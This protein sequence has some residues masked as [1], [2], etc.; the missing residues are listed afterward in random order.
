MSSATSL[1]GF[2]DDATHLG[3][4][5]TYH[6]IDDR[7]VFQIDLNI[8]PGELLFQL[9]DNVDHF[10]PTAGGPTTEETIELVFDDLIFVD[11]Q[12]GET[13]TLDAVFRVIDDTP[14]VDVIAFNQN[15]SA[16][17]WNLDETTDP[18]FD[19]VA[20]EGLDTYGAGDSLPHDDDG[21][22]D[23]TLSQSADPTGTFPFGS[24]S[25]GNLGGLF[26]VN[27]L[28]G[29]DGEKSDDRTLTLKLIEFGVGELAV[30]TGL[31]TTLEATQPASGGNPDSNGADAIPFTPYADPGIYLFLEPGGTA[32]TGRVGNS[33]SGPIAFRITLTT[34]DPATAQLKVDQ[35]LAIDHPTTPDTFDEQLNLG[36][37]GDTS[38]GTIEGIALNLSVTLTDGD[39]DTDTDDHSAFITN[40]FRFDDDGP[41]I[42]QAN[43]VISA[44]LEL[45]ELIVLPNST[46]DE[47]G[48]VAAGPDDQAGVTAVNG[49]NAIGLDTFAVGD[50]ISGIDFGQDGGTA[51]YSLIMKTER[52]NEPIVTQILSTDFFATHPAP[53]GNPDFDGGGQFEPYPASHDLGQIFLFQINP[54]TIEGYVGEDLGAPVGPL[55]L[56]IT[57]DPNTGVLTMQQYLAL[58]H[59]DTTDHDDALVGDSNLL[60]GV[61]AKLTATDGDGDQASLEIPVDVRIE[62]DGPVAVLTFSS[63]TIVYDETAGLDL[64]SNDVGGT[65]P[66]TV[67]PAGLGT[68]IGRAAITGWFQ[69]TGSNF[70]TDGAAAVN[71]TPPPVTPIGFSLAIFAPGVDSGLDTV[72]GRSIFL[73]VENGLVVG[74]PETTIGSGAPGSGVGPVA[75]VLAVNGTNGNFSVNQYM[76]IEHGNPLDP[77]ESATP[78]TFDANTVFGR[79]RVVDGDGDA[80]VHSIDISLLIKIEDDGSIAV[81]DTDD[82]GIGNS[83]TGNVITD[84]AAGDAGDTDAGADT[85]GTDGGAISGVAAGD[86]NT[87]ITDGTGVGGLGVDGTFGTLILNADGSYTYNRTS[88]SGG[89]DVFTYTLKDGDG[90]ADTATLT[91]DLDPQTPPP[92]QGEGFSAAI[93]EDQLNPASIGG[94]RFP[95]LATGNEDED[96]VAGLDTDEDATPGPQEFNNITHWIINDDNSLGV[97]GG[98]APLDFHFVV[99]NGTQ[100]LING[101]VPLTSEG[102]AVL[103]HTLPDGNTLIGY[104]ETFGGSGYQTGDR[105]VFDMLITSETG[106]GQ[107]NFILYDNID[108]HPY[109]GTVLNPAGLPIDNVEN[110]VALNLNGVI[111]VT[112]AN[113]DDLLLN[114]EIQIIDDIPIA[115]ADSAEV[116]FGETTKS[117]VVLIIDRSGSMAG[118]FNTV[119]QAIEDL[120]DSGLV[121]SVR[122]LSFSDGASNQFGPVGGWFTDLDAAFFAVNAL[123][124]DG[125]TDYDA[126]LSLL[127]STYSAPPAGGDRLI[128]LFLSDGE[129]NEDNGTGSDGIDEDDTDGNPAPG[130]EETDWINFLTTNGFDASYAIGFGGLTDADRAHLEPI[131]WQS[132]ETADNPYDA[133]DNGVGGSALDDPN[134]IITNVNDLAQVLQEATGASIAGNVITN[135]TVTTADDD[136]FG[137]DGPGYVTTL[138]WDTDGDGDVDGVDDAGYQFN[139]TALSLN[140]GAFVAGGEAT[141]DTFFD[142]SFTF[143][144]LTGDWEYTT[145]DTVNVQFIEHFT[146][147]LSDGDGDQTAATALNITVL[148]PPP[149]FTVSDATVVD[150]GDKTVFEINLSHAA[151]GP[152]V[153]SLAFTNGS[154]EGSDYNS[155]TY[156]FSTDG[157]SYSNVVGNQITIPTS[158]TQVFVRVQTNEDADFDDETFT[159]T[160]TKVSGPT[161]TTSDAGSA[162]I[163]DD[164]NAAPVLALNSLLAVRD[165]FQTVAYTNQNGTAN[166]S[167]NWSE[168]GDDGNAAIDG[169][170]ADDIGIVADANGGAPAGNSALRVSDFIAGSGTDGDDADASIQRQV[171]LIGATTATLTFDHRSILSN[172][173]DDVMIQVA[174]AAGG[175]FTTLLT[176]DGSNNDTNYDDASFNISAF[177]SATTT[178]RIVSTGAL[179]EDD[180]VFFDNITITYNAASE[181]FE[182]TYT[183][184]GAPASIAAAGPTIS[185]A[186]DTQMEFANIVLA[187]AQAGDVLS[188]GALP[189][190]ILSTIVLGVGTITVQLS[191]TASLAAYQAAIQ[192]VAFSTTSDTPSPVDRI[193]NVTVNDGE[194]DSNIAT[195]TMN[196]VPVS[197][198]PTD[199]LVTGNSGIAV[200]GGGAGDTTIASGTV[201]FTLS[202]VDPDDISG[203]TYTFNG[204]GTAA[205]T[206]DGD[207]ETFTMN[208]TTGAVT[209]TALAYGNPATVVMSVRSTD[210]D[211][212]ARNETVTLRLGENGVNDTLDQS[213]TT[214]DQVIYGL[215]GND[216]LLGGSARDWLNGGAG[217]DT[218]TGGG[219]AD[220]IDTGAANDDVQDII[221]FNNVTEY[222]DLVS[223]FDANG[224]DVTDDRILFGGALN[225]L[226]DDGNDDENFLSATG[227]GIAG[228]VS[229]NVGDGNS[230][231]ELLLLTGAGGEGVTNA[232]LTNAALV[233]AAFNAEFNI[234]AANGNDAVLVINDTDANSFAVWQYIESTGGA[235]IAA[236]EIT[237]IGRFDANGAISTGNL[238]LV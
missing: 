10:E 100:A 152:I 213:I 53:G 49:V 27:K 187:N 112:D 75:I 108:H 219:G 98:V 128:S 97:A 116:A 131:A 195:T 30:G 60:E 51:N 161:A 57:I 218:M 173:N 71:P 154:A 109:G 47:S 29:A 146:Y 40:R 170:G 105:V 175:P 1:F 182:T 144:F 194:V 164:D 184:N 76:A 153:L 141:F 135:L 43:R 178:I 139:G 156:E 64:D 125:S 83:E 16:Q 209:T 3:A 157:I 188:V 214:N 90:D 227:N 140:G 199:I 191:G 151:S 120:F 92:G 223:N 159:L 145:P 230:D 212:A 77:D 165:T 19:D 115:L 200:G 87:A 18:D 237:L 42:L 204:A 117:D 229:A 231:I 179:E 38:N 134:V 6:V 224:T 198:P 46:L 74:R 12:D 174:S 126:A 44:D 113:G 228:A 56:R 226:F 48:T 35:F 93:E 149:T 2:V 39:N 94:P 81:N 102:A 215:G 104:A 88:V 137:A 232:N 58:R 169:T 142:G 107:F 65:T 233:A 80:S 148:P 162:L 238:D 220:T 41:R 66:Y 132:P 206:V 73:Y 68:L 96:D 203:F 17:F 235:E 106:A 222:G 67:P 89:Q 160:A 186:N 192:A 70:G 127:M 168:T 210:D 119:K 84:A 111:E 20:D 110:F 13:G 122:I 234:T 50:L 118:I 14:D 24:I 26:T 171:N 181:D 85:L 59:G 31:Q 124:A 32:I 133:D 45:D 158:D 69:S 216:T 167:T 121:N 143:N 189:P 34:D 190:G 123:V 79:V 114:G 33:A 86:T 21:D 28:P 211:G 172:G 166:W 176:L 36:I 202:S 72:D 54:T 4:D 103:Y 225:T 25:H 205:V 22:L 208:P 163:N 23:D 101:D 62:D 5:T 207:S 78:E 91:I 236:G 8:V 196:V 201:L 147:R 7:L 95:I 183:E 82:V 193:I 150:E 177:I 130:G 61:L 180:L 197:D 217:N 15:G 11:D 99:P 138:R 55:A 136:L 155:V 185:D 221:R 9:F 129:P 52:D 63:P 37:A